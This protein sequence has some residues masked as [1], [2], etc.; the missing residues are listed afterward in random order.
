MITLV[1]IFVILGLSYVT[2]ELIYYR[3]KCYEFFN[4]LRC[5]QT[6]FYYEQRWI[7]VLKKTS[8]RVVVIKNIHDT[9]EVDYENLY[10][11]ITLF[12]KWILK[13]K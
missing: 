7:V 1:T 4:S 10:Q 11:H 13:R 8:L 12:E 3:H 2:I 5:G 6:V 9:K